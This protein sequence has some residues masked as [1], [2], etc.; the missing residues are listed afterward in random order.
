M[1]LGFTTYA[2]YAFEKAFGERDVFESIVQTID[3]NGHYFAVGHKISPPG[4]DERTMVIYKLD[5]S[6][7]IVTTAD[8]SKPDTA[9]H[10]K[11]CIPKTN[12]NLLC[13]GS[14]KR[15]DNPLRGGRHTY[16]CEISSNLELLWEKKLIPL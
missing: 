10:V 8:F 15:T 1:Q 3:H 7:D 2:Q 13:F 14:L 16:V 12:G 5:Y 9:Y 4:N 11:F 6:G